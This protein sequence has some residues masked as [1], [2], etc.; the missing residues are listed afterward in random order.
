MQLLQWGNH[1][2]L[3]SKRQKH[4]GN[5]CILLS[6]RS[7]SEKATYC[8]I[9]TTDILVKVKLWK[10]KDQWLSGVLGREQSIGREK[11]I[12]MA[13]KMLCVIL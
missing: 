6:E 1:T 11:R 13:V 4:G 12:F 8:M 7:R 2:L 5:K 10:Q 9:P 3:N